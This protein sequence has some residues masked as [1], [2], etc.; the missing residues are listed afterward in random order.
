MRNI[1]RY[2]NIISQLKKH[3]IAILKKVTSLSNEEQG[4]QN[5]DQEIIFFIVKY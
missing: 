4:L 1:L 2:I 5:I 3:V